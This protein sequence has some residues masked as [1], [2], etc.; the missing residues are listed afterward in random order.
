MNDPALPPGWEA[1][2]HR[3]LTEPVMR[4]GVPQ[5]LAVTIW[6]I[7]AGGSFALHQFWLLPIGAVAHLAGALLTRSDP[8]FFKI[9]PQALW[10]QRRLEP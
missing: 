9:L 4:A 5:G 2:L 3:S 10:A 6:V 1:P 8:Y 7:V